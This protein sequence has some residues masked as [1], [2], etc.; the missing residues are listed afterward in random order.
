LHPK[1]FSLTGGFLQSLAKF[2]QVF[3]KDVKIATELLA[4]LDPRLGNGYVLV[5]VFRL[6][7]VKKI[8]VA[9][10]PQILGIKSRRFNKFW[11]IFF[12]KLIATFVDPLLRIA[13]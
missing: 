2:L 9:L 10:C 8:G 11:H 12:C 3:G 13:I 1:L 5:A 6:P 4:I 7:H